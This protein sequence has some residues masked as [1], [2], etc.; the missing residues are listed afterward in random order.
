MSILMKWFSNRK[1]ERICLLV[2]A[3][4]M[5]LL[6]WKL[7]SVLQRDFTEVNA[8]LENGTTFWAGRE[9]PHSVQR[10]ATPGQSAMIGKAWSLWDHVRVL[11]FD[12]S[13][14]VRVASQE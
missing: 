7:F 10:A 1:P 11:F 5:G 8:R 2:I 6:F 4:I 9:S 12:N 3:V 13:V 14:A